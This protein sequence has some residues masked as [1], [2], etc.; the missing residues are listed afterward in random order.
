[1]WED[2]QLSNVD[3][4]VFI[5]YFYLKEKKVNSRISRAFVFLSETKQ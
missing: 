2:S 4:S 5:F 3:H 1:M